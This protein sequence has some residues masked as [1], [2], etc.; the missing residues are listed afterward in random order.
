MKT[1]GI[2]SSVALHGPNV[3]ITEEMIPDVAK[4]PDVMAFA[5][6]LFVGRWTRS[7]IR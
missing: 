1:L 4:Q 6:E 2:S 5:N 3:R 7:M